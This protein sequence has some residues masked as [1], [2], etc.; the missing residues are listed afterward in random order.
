MS[1]K[2]R[3]ANIK[4]G[5]N[6]EKPRVYLQGRWLVEAGFSPAGKITVIFEKDKIIIRANTEGDRKISGKG[7]AAVIDITGDKLGA[8]FGEKLG[9]P[10]LC[11]ARKGEIV[12]T[13]AK[14]LVKKAARVLTAIAVSLFAGGGLLDEAA[15]AEGFQ[16]VAAVEVEPAYAE[17][18]E[19]NH[20][21]NMHEQPIEEVDFQ[22]MAARIDQPV[23][24]LTAGRPCEPYSNIR[25]LDRGGQQKRDKSLPPEAHE[26]GHLDFYVLQ[27]V[28]VL[29]PHT[30]V[31][32]NVPGYLDAGSG[33]MVQGV[34]RAMG[35]TVDSRVLNAL[36]Y[37]S[38]QARRRA[39]I[40]ATTFD[41][42]RWPETVTQKLT[43]AS[44]LERIPDDSPLWFGLDHWAPQHWARQ[45]AK[46]NG[47]AA[48]AI[49]AADTQIP[50]L[51]KRYYAGQGDN[52][53]VAH[54]TQANTWRWLTLTEGRRLMGLPDDYDLGPTKTNAG[55]VLGQGI[56]IQM[57]RH[58]LSAITGCRRKQAAAA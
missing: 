38:L 1:E 30:V 54:P 37:G 42:V 10:L 57:F 15:H 12:I 9:T 36:D 35:Y 21:G 58:V 25:R 8:V 24:L 55:E 34:L 45:S 32:E 27:A 17:I 22:K 43:A 29:N 4:L 20:A 47:F 5:L 48:P 26:L 16:T 2:L 7:E 41:E 51:K 23:G 49:T 13:K 53:V 46:G 56:D 3:S 40:I 33:Y 52:F 44:I 19:R 28:D 31:I 11:E 18:W 14:T 6:K 39:I 50:T